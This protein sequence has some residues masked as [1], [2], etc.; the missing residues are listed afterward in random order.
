MDNI[1]KFLLK[2]NKSDRKILEELFNA[3]RA[4]NVEKYDVKP[5]KGFKGVYRLLTG[6]IRIV[7]LKDNKKGI[8]LNVDYRKNIYQKL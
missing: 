8:I 3:I 5:L 1:E 2:L 6:K 4:L 7:F